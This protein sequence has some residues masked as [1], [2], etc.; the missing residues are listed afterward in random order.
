MIA[1]TTIIPILS[2]FFAAIAGILARVLLKDTPA[3]KMLAINFLIMGAAL[4]LLSPFSTLDA[5]N[6]PTLYMFR[7]LI[8]GFFYIT[9]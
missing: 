4:L 8:N 6:A 1:L 5:T 3:K 9:L 2:S 7:A